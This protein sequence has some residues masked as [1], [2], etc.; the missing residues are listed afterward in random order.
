MRARTVSASLFVAAALAVA[1]LHPALAHDGGAGKGAT[2][3]A[4]AKAKAAAKRD[5]RLI[6]AKAQHKRHFVVGGEVTAVDATAGTLSF[7][8]HGGRYKPLRDTVVTVNVAPDAKV[9]RDG[10]ATLADVLV[11]DHVVVKATDFQLTVVTSSVEGTVTVSLSL[12]ATVS[13]VAA[14]PPG[15]D[16]EDETEAVVPAS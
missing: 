12:T 4:A 1:P 5:A 15:A 11:G 2:K 10:V 8:V 13:R 14:S 16:V 6:E 7:T 9:T 3:S